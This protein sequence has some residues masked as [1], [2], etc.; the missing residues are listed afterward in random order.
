MFLIFLIDESRIKLK[1]FENIDLLH[2]SISYIAD[3]STEHDF[4]FVQGK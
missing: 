4:I 1:N 2:K 3:F